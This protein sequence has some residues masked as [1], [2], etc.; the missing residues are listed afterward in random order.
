MLHSASKQ[1]EKSVLPNSA[2]RKVFLV[3]K[4]IAVSVI[5]YGRSA[6]E[7]SLCVTSR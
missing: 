7:L 2:G 3:I 1:N 4:I 5:V 6:A